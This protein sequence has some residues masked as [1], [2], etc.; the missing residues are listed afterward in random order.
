[1]GRIARI[2]KSWIATRASSPGEA[3]ISQIKAQAGEE[4]TVE[5]WHS[6]GVVSIPT[7]DDRIAILGVGNGNHRIGI[8]TQNYR[9]EHDLDTGETM[10]YSTNAAGD[11]VQATVKL[12]ASGNID[13]N[14]D[15]KRLVTF[16]ELDTA[17]AAFKSS[18]DTAIAGAIT[19]HTHAGVTTGPGTSG[20]G[21]GAAPATSLDIS[22]AETATVRTG[23]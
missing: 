22:A 7:P 1:M 6:P 2:V 16:D 19:G 12:D 11:T 21:V 18:I 17:L 23:G 14:G 9:I 10:I 13:L 20:P 5:L 4:R 3:V 15:S 8:A